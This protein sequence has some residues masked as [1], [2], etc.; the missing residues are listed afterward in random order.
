MKA[1]TNAGEGGTSLELHRIGNAAL[2]SVAGRWMPADP[3][4]RDVADDD[5]GWAAGVRLEN[6]A[7][8]V[9]VA[10]DDGSGRALR[11]VVH[12]VLP[13]S[14]AAW[15]TTLDALPCRV[16]LGHIRPL[17][18][19]AS[20]TATTDWAFR[21]GW[22]SALDYATELWRYAR[23]FGAMPVTAPYTPP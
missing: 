15:R 8:L 18:S 16:S 13:T 3:V 14:D 5:P 6:S 7:A 9:V 4:L 20:A 19:R 22:W 1:G 23:L 2:L 11:A 12:L 21:A 17:L 10:D